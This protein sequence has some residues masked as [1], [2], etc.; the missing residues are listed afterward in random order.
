MIIIIVRKTGEVLIWPIAGHE[1]FNGSK[2]YPH[3]HIETLG[4]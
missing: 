4:M 2:K 3:W 1:T